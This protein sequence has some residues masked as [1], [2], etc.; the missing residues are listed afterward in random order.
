M[1]RE[2]RL[3]SRMFGRETGRLGVSQ[4]GFHLLGG[5]AWSPRASISTY[6]LIR[7]AR[8]LL[9]LFGLLDGGRARAYRFVRVS[10]SHM[11]LRSW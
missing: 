10:T 1:P 6:W 11:G 2:R 4:A 8:V 3:R 9:T 5:T 7:R